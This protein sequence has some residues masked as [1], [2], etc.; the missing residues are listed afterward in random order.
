[1]VDSVDPSNINPRS[2]SSLLIVSS[3]RGEAETSIESDRTRN[4]N[5]I[6]IIPLSYLSD[7]IAHALLG[8]KRGERWDT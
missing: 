4:T 1:M 5:W 7:G 6:W 2:L 3:L 8:Y